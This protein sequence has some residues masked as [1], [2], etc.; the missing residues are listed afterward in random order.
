MKRLAPTMA[1][2][3]RCASSV[4]WVELLRKPSPEE[5]RLMGIASLHPSYALWPRT[6]ICA[7]AKPVEARV[8]VVRTGKK[9]RRFEVILASLLVQKAVI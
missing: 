5:Q 1:G 6:T 2:G 9:T 4:G 8:M 3:L 7:E